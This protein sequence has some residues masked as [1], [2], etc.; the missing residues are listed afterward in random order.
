MPLYDAN[1]ALLTDNGAAFEYL[2]HNL[3]KKTKGSQV[4]DYGYNIENRLSQVKE[5]DT[6]LANYGYDPFG[7][8]LWKEVV[9]HAI[10]KRYII[11]LNHLN[12]RCSS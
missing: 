9:L 11:Y 12:I 1:N 4:T 3:V 2:N 7:R 6:P 5:D 8:R 10:G